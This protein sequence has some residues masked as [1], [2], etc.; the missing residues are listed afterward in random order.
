MR[1]C[2]LWR[3]AVSVA[4]SLVF[5]G[6][7]PLLYSAD[8]PV[9]QVILYKHGVGYFERN[10]T[11][12]A[13]REI[14]LTF[15]NA[16]MNDV[17]K[18]LTVVDGRGG[19]VT[20]VR[21]DSNE[22]LDQKL[23]KYP[24]TIGENEYLAT[25]L[26]RVKGSRIELRAAANSTTG[27]ILAARVVQAGLETDRRV[28]KEELTLLLD[29][30]T[31]QNFDLGGSTSIR[32]L[33][34]RLQDQLKQYLQTLAEAKS[35]EKR[36][37]YIDG[38]SAGDRDLRISYI[39][40]TAIWKPSYRLNLGQAPPTLEGWAIVDNTTDEDWNNI[41]LSVVSGRPISFI[42]LLDSPRYGRRQ[43]AE[44]PEDRAAG[45]VVYG[46]S[47]D[48]KAQAG[49]AG[50]AVGGVIGGMLS[51][52]GNGM[53]YGTSAGL[54]PPPAP[55]AV[56]R[57]GGL[58][59]AMGKSSVEG[60]T[61]ATLGELFEYS[62]AGPITIT[63][64]QSAM[65]PFLQEKITARKL[66]IYTER[67]GEHPINAAEIT[68]NTGKTLDGGPVTVYDGAYA[69][70]A[71][72]ETFK[73]G[74]KRLV[75]YAVDYGT[76]VTSAFGTNEQQIREIHVRNG[77]ISVRYANREQ[78]T[79]T[80]R[81]VD[82]TPK[83]LIIEQP[84]LHDYKVLSPEPIERTASA[85][86]FEVKLAANST[87]ALRVEQ[88][89]PW[90]NTLTLESTTPNDLL[91]IVSNKE[92]SA[93]D[94]SRLQSIADLKRQIAELSASAAN[95]K[96]QIDDLTADENRL[97]QN[98]DSLNRVKGQED[99]V[100]KYSSDL[101]VNEASLAQLRDRSR[102]LM[103]QKAAADSRLRDSIQKLEF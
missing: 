62:F 28:V 5:T 61:G 16:E 77:I 23:H 73:T 49:E 32:L 97:R 25:F 11:V 46:G 83:T 31:V 39:S 21:Y 7:A 3:G 67:G 103:Q 53:R 33:D 72:F 100:R 14:S 45:P 51:D 102:L 98:I 82:S 56:A 81:N 6:T 37:I 66:L 9:K 59:E 74:D 92:I 8:I 78:R 19:H 22:T 76:R 4:A 29:S 41:N 13:G 86:R 96:S 44:L 47:V 58:N 69:G 10:G 94:R 40:P 95:T 48:V 93:A 85:Y 34:Q 89:R 55:L 65:L 101:A 71:L 60:A 68:N 27:T 12:S 2:L 36:T 20:A 18:S 80:I 24:F 17:L 64:N 91:A 87:Q 63:K 1:A 15:R 88:E 42:S 35:A 54:A 99:Q 52:S 75:G 50:G 30:G 79:Y 84:G 26:D 90:M 57:L 43:V 38:S 70:E